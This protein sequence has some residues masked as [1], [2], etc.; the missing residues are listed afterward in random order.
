M[1]YFFA[2]LV[3]TMLLVSG[4]EEAP[5][6]PPPKPAATPA[7]LL[8]PPKPVVT[9][10]ILVIGDSIT[11]GSGESSFAWPALVWSS[12]KSSVGIVVPIIAGEGAAGYV[13]PGNTGS[14]FGE[15]AALYTSPQDELVVF[16]GSSNDSVASPSVLASAVR[17]TFAKTKAAAP[18]AKLLVIGP[19]ALSP[20]PP[21]RLH[22]YPAFSAT[23]HKP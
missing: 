5:V 7:T 22:E 9:H 10:H 2:V 23:K 8:P 12:L 3:S 20:S 14:T 18:A 6:V 19:V 1:K 21:P 11:Q 17:D 16:F 13:H 15:R 4:C